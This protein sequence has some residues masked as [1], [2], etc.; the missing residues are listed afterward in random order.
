MS[1]I[2]VIRMDLCELDASGRK[3]PKEV[4]GSEFTIPADVVIIAVGTGA[5]PLIAQSSKD[6]AVTKHQY[7]IADEETGKTSKEGFYAGGDIV[8][9]AATVISAMG[10][11]RKAAK[12]INEYLR[13]KPVTKKS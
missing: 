5:N 7:V 8:T 13:T 6:I 4:P 1:A 12:A 2:E 3:K 9:G 11:G 10:A